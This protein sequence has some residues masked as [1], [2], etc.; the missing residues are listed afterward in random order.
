MKKIRF[1]FVITVCILM[2][3]CLHADT[4]LQKEE[5]QKNSTLDMEADRYHP[6]WTI[7]GTGNLYV[8]KNDWEQSFQYAVRRY[9]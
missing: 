6:I 9:L 7:S 3:G 2:G 4:E 8:R 5:K 1:L